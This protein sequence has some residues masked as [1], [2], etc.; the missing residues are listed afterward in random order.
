VNGCNDLA[1]RGG[2]T[3]TALQTEIADAAP[4]LEN[5]RQQPRARYDKRLLDDVLPARDTILRHAAPGSDIAGADIFLQ[6]A[7][8]RFVHLRMFD[9]A[10]SNAIFTFS[11]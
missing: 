8:N 4:H 5:D 10:D 9:H 1:G 7:P 6:G 2:F 11:S 3:I